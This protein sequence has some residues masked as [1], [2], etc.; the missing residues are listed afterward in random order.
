MPRF[1]GGTVHFDLGD[2]ALKMSED[3]IMVWYG[4]GHCFEKNLP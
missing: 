4:M 3:S 2:A 1:L